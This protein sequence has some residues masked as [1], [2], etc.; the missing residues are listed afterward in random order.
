LNQGE[1][2][3]GKLGLGLGSLGQDLGYSSSFIEFQS[4]KFGLFLIFLLLGYKLG[5]NFQ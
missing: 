1:H 3:P 2:D 5:K 4:M